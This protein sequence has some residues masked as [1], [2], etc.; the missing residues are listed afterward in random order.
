MVYIKESE[1]ID[2][3]LVFLI[4]IFA[5]GFFIQSFIKCNKKKNNYDYEDENIDLETVEAD[6]NIM[7]NK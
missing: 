7:N 2:V 6:L 5:L 1:D 3:Y 4:L